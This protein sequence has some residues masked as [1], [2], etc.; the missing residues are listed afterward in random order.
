LVGMIVTWLVD[1]NTT[2]RFWITSTWLLR[3][4]FW[5][6]SLLAIGNFILDLSI[7][8][9]SNYFTDKLVSVYFMMWWL[10]PAR[11]LTSATH[12]FLWDPIEKSTQRKIPNLIRMFSSSTIF[13]VAIFGI[14]AFIFDQKL[15]SLL[16]TGG[17]FAMVIGLAIQS[18]ISNIFSGIV[19]NIERPYSV[20]DWIKI[21]GLD[22]TEVVDITWRTLRLR[23]WDGHS[24]S[25]PNGRAAEST[26]I[27]YSRGNVRID[28]EICLSPTLVP[29]FIQEQLQKI[30]NS[31]EGIDQVETP[32]VLYAGT[33]LDW[34][35]N[36]NVYEVRFWI[37]D[38]TTGLGYRTRLWNQIWEDLND[39]GISMIAQK[40]V[41][42]TDIDNR[43]K[44]S[45][46]ASKM[47]KGDA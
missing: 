31:V 42:T 28:V 24:I 20:G 18:N 26:T 12:R 8:N 13:L 36:V 35:H 11:L 6:I 14:I 2:S 23:T 45:M 40:A 4:F 46:L 32:V 44:D 29:V 38:Y 19:V 22:D 33:R 43:L 30:A 34:G 21:E 37:S 3:C 17:L 15:T 10:M 1:A 25:M 7:Q 5:P 41:E 47:I 9:L 39:Q 27:N 16:A